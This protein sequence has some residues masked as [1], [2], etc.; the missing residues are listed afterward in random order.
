VVPSSSSTGTIRSCEQDANADA[1]PDTTGTAGGTRRLS[2]YVWAGWRLHES[3][4]VFH[5][6]STQG[7]YRV[8]R[9]TGSAPCGWALADLTTEMQRRIV[10]DSPKGKGLPMTRPRQAPRRGLPFV[11][12]AMAVMVFAGPVGSADLRAPRGPADWPQYG[13]DEANTHHNPF[14]TILDPSN[15]GQVHA[16]WRA[17]EGANGPPAVV[18]SVVYACGEEKPRVY[19]L[20]ALMGTRLWVSEPAIGCLSPAVSGGRVFATNG[21]KKLYALDAATGAELWAVLISNSPQDKGP[22]KVAGDA[23]YV[24]VGDGLVHAIDAAAGEIRWTASTGVVTSAVAV[25]DGRIYVRND[26]SQLVAL[27]AVSGARL[28]WVDLEP[29][30][31]EI[32]PVFVDG[33]IYTIGSHTVYALDAATGATLWT[34]RFAGCLVGNPTLG[35]GV[36]YLPHVCVLLQRRGGLRRGDRRGA[37]AYQGARGNFLPSS[38]VTANGVA[39]VST[40]SDESNLTYMNMLDAATGGRLA[41]VRLGHATSHPPAPVVVN[42]RIY[43]TS[44]TFSPGWLYAMGL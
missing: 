7:T 2:Y 18:D 13:F 42:G 27:D 11:S 40:Q 38:I 3:D 9:W 8:G 26:T 41:K 15:V 32:D 25:G 43:V 14:E 34:I 37:L 39:Y 35:N 22:P 30:V 31:S 36:V 21:E 6:A 24:G 5:G 33:V 10:V 23:V 17:Q 44:T 16:L 20:D 1:L 12:L 19:A 29:G 28:W 4:C